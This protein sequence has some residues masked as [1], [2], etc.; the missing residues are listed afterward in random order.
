[1]P[2]RQPLQH[3]TA[4]ILS[5]DGGRAEL[6]GGVEGQGERSQRTLGFPRDSEGIGRKGKTRDTV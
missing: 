3:R 2:L 6:F 1:M 5:T 4:V